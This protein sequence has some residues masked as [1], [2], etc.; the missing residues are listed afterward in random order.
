MDSLE[1]PKPLTP[2]V[3]SNQNAAAEPKSMQ[4]CVDNTSSMLKLLDLTQKNLPNNDSREHDGDK[5]EYTTKTP[6]PK[7]KTTS[8]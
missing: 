4:N 5:D 1:E 6:P 8:K 2:L 3:V 7:P